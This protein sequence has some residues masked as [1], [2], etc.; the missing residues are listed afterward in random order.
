ML[1]EQMEDRKNKIISFMRE[2]SYH[3]L[4]FSELAVVLD[5][6]AAETSELQNLLNI[7]ENEGL[8]IKT[9]KDR[10]GVPERMGLIVGKFQ[11]HARGF[12]FVIPDVGDEDVF[13]PANAINGAMNGDRVISR[14]SHQAAGDR[15]REGEIIQIIEHANKTIVGKFDKSDH[16]GFVTPDHT[17]LSGDIFIPKDYINGAKKGQK[18]VVEITKWPEKNRNAE[19]RITEVLGDEGETGVDVMSIIRAY[20]IHY[21][22]PDLVLHEAQSAPQ[23]VSEAEMRGRRDLRA[24]RMVTIDGCPTPGRK[25]GT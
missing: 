13:I 2:Q 23:E 22:F 11:G 4:K 21:E 17:R 20:G 5:V 24:L 19:G 14:L 25:A 16:F 15:R 8:V 12:G 7:M 10:Y 6:P 1:N 18:V 3:P 9:R